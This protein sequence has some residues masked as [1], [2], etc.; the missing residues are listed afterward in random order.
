MFSGITRGTFEVVRLV[1][2]PGLLRYTVDLGEL[3]QGLEIGASVSIDGVCQSAV[4]VEGSW[5]SFE[6]VA[7][8]LAMTTL[9]GLELGRRVSVE[10]AL[11]AGDELG[12]HDVSGHI[13][14][15][16]RVERVEREGGRHELWVLVPATWGKYLMPKGF[17][18]LDGSS[19]TVAE[20]ERR[21]DSAR[22]SVHLVP[23][24][25]R[26]TA[27]GAKR[28][29][30]LLNVEL[31]ARTVAIVDTVERVLAERAAFEASRA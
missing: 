25:V 6:A 19:L 1:R 3:A 16:G 23:E 28:A 20:L 10:R 14:G 13:H 24:T 31:D 26:V 7:Q 9:D 29:G 18:A 8:T 11:R 12:G 2:E 22:F 21:S 5:V 17:V 4:A 27:L 30:D 15:V